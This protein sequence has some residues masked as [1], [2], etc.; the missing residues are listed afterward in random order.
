MDESTL[1]V[2]GADG[3]TVVSSILFPG[4]TSNGL[5]LYVKKGNVTLDQAVFYPMASIWRDEDPDGSKPLRVLL[6]H[7]SVDVPL[8]GT[9]EAEAAVVPLT[10]PQELTWLSSD[11]TVAQVDSR[12][13]TSAV[14]KGVKEGH[15]EIKVLAP[16]GQ[17]YA[18]MNVFV[19]KPD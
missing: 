15:A 3:E 19:Y 7:S 6:S 5:E 9:A 11:E 8:G 17:I 16:G 14:V 4:A 2:F 13:G 18:V 12:T 10:A 1:E